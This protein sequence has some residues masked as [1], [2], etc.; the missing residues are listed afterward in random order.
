MGVRLRIRI[1]LSSDNRDWL[2]NEAKI[3]FATNVPVQC[4]EEQGANAQTS[5]WAMGN[6]SDRA[7]D[8]VWPGLRGRIVVHLW[9]V[10]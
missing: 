4:E 3:E 5:R 8:C 7:N 9:L 6:G 10:S 2:M 1:V